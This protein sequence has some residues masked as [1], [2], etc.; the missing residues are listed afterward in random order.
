MPWVNK[1]K[2]IGCGACLNVCPV[3]AITVKDGQAEIDQNKCIRCGKCRVIC[4]Q[5][6]I[7]PN[8]ENP[9]LRGHRHQN[10]N[11]S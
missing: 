7:R 8:S 3:G 1:N 9:E 2:C 5:E 6:A 10:Q 11:L 4:P